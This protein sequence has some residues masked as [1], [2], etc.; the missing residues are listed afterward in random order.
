MGAS[1]KP[2]PKP[3][4]GCSHLRSV[5]FVG[6]MAS[7]WDLKLKTFSP[8]RRVYILGYVFGAVHCTALHC[9]CSPGGVLNYLQAPRD[10]RDNEYQL[11]ARECSALQDSE[12]IT[13]TFIRL[14]Y[15]QVQQYHIHLGSHGRH[16]K[17]EGKVTDRQNGAASNAAATTQTPPSL[18]WYH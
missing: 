16:V 17:Q 8:G 1:L 6:V 3:Y 11:E 18:Y 5:T 10:P 4:V 12:G 13:S 9:M 15:M 14:L 2:S 7:G